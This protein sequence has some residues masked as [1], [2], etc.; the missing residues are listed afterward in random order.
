MA[1][2]VEKDNKIPSS[3]GSRCFAVKLLHLQG[4]SY[5]KTNPNITKHPK[6]HTKK[7]RK[8]QSTVQTK[9]IF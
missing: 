3:Y 4:I 6:K 2:M 7:N 5:T 1:R 9:L 8:R